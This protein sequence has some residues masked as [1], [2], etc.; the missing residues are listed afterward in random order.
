MGLLKPSL[1][2][3]SYNPKIIYAVILHRYLFSFTIIMFTTA[4]KN[5]T[6]IYLKKIVLLFFDRTINSNQKCIIEVAT[7]VFILFLL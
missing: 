5:I 2:Q 4:G 6:E 1:A 7:T 3:I